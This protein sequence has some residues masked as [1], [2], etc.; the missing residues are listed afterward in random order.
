MS[1]VLQ[2]RKTEVP[3]RTDFLGTHDASKALIESAGENDFHPTVLEAG[4][5]TDKVDLSRFIQRSPVAK[6]ESAAVERAFHFTS[7]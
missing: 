3:S 7:L 5:V 4:G 6:A 1:S 2:R